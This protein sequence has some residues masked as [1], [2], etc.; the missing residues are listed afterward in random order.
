MKYL[1][2]GA[3]GFLG[4]EIVRQLVRAGHEVR[5]VVRDLQ[6]A[7]WME[8]LGVK[9]YKGDVTE[10]ESMREAMT[11]VDGIYHVAAWYKVVERTKGEAFAVNVQGTTNVLELMQDLKIP[12]GVYTSTCAVFSNTRGK[13]VNE[14]YHFSGK[15]ATRYEDTKGAAHAIAKKFIAQGLPL[16][17]AQPGM[18]YGPNDTSSVRVSLIEFLKGNLPGLPARSVMCWAHVEDTAR[19][20]IAMMETGRAGEAYIIAGEKSTTADMFRVAGEVSG[21][22]MPKLIPDGVFRFL[23]FFARPFDK[24]LP[25][26]FTSQGMIAI[27]GLSYLADDGKARRELGFNPRPIREGWVETVRH[28]MKLLGMK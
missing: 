5:A 3:T 27:S 17:I 19:A 13:T 1:V 6:K 7:K 25:D 4:G 11:G 8:E 24:W 22:K 26:T 16:V 12:K 14:T 18:I 15:Y 9:L 10:K 21:V 23:A 28:E 20:H 2:T